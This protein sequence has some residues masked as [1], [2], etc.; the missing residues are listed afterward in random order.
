LIFN[1]GV[2]TLDKDYKEITLLQ[3]GQGK[4][5]QLINAE[6]PTSKADFIAQRARGAYIATI[7]QPEASF[8]LSSAAQRQ[9]PQP[10]DIKALNVRLKWQMENQ[11]RGLQMIPLDLQAIKLFVFVDAAFA[12]NPDLSSQI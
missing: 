5:L 11:G 10:E 4:Q 9:N 8:D 1:G 2:I 7:C 3:K 6:S 12:N